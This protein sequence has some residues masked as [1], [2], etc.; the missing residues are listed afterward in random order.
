MLMQEIRNIAQTAG[1]KP[2]KLGKTEL[3]RAIQRQEGN[4]DCYASPVNGQCD[5][6][7]C[8]WREDCLPPAKA[9]TKRKTKA[10]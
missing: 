6:D 7:E 10:A 2:G 1:I 4:F 9:P 8:L 3:I 5:Q